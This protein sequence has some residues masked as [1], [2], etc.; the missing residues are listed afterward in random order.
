MNHFLY[1]LQVLGVANP[2]TLKI[3][4][5]FGSAINAYEAITGGDYSFLKPY[6]IDRLKYSSLDESERMLEFCEN[7]GVRTVAYF[8]EDYPEN[9]KNIFNPPLVLFALGNLK[10]LNER[11]CI[12]VIG[13]RKASEYALQAVS[14]ICEP[15]AKIGTVIISGFAVGIDV[16]A[17]SAAMGAGGITA[18]V[19]ACGID[20]DYPKGSRNFRLDVANSGGAVL[21]ECLPGMN[22]SR[23]AFQIRN[24]LMSGLAQG[25]LIIEAGEQSGCHITAS[26]AIN[27]NRDLF[28]LPPKNIFDSGVTGTARYLRDGAIPV[29]DYTDI[30]N[31]YQMYYGTMLVEYKQSLKDGEPL[32]KLENFTPAP[33]PAQAKKASGFTNNGNEI[34]IIAPANP[35]RPEVLPEKIPAAR[36]AEITAALSAE[37][38]KIYE[39]LKTEPNGLTVDEI[40]AK[41]EIPVD[42]VN[43]GLLDLEIEGLA[44]PIGGAR[45]RAN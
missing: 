29:F 15:L 35:V 10:P 7:N 9:L 37:C 12:N 1:L 44:D 42:T 8:D 6:E 28:C 34:E 32:E 38:R 25:T 11:I 33:K 22:T 20:V 30:I 23:S 24:R 31:A 17:M 36:I 14:V 43:C 5:K 13:R 2:R 3:V 21:T 26:H 19:L 4:N 40:S 16:T 18:G 27:Q 39:L 41:T 45:Y